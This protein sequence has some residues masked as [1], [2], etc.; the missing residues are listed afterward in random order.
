MDDLLS[1]VKTTKTQSKH[2]ESK[3]ILTVEANK[4]STIPLVEELRSPEQ[5]IIILQSRPSLKALVNVLRWLHGSTSNRA[6]FNIHCPSPKAAQIIHL[7]VN[8]VLPSY[9]SSLRREAKDLLVLTLSNLAGISAIVTRMRFLSDCNNDHGEQGLIKEDEKARFL[10]DLL[11][12][13]DA[14]LKR[15]SFILFLWTNLAAIY[16]DSM[17]RWISWKEVVALL[18]SGRLLSTASQADDVVA[19][20]ASTTRQRSW[21][22]DGSRYSSWIGRNLGY[23]LVSSEKTDG[24]RRKAWVHMLQRALT[25]G[26]PGEKLSRCKVYICHTPAYGIVGQ[27]IEA[28]YSGTIKSS[29]DLVS[30][31]RESTMALQGSTRRVVLYSLLRMY[32]NIYFSSPAAKYKGENSDRRICCVAALIHHFLGD[33]DNLTGILYSWLTGAGIVQDL[34]LRRAVIAALAVKPGKTVAE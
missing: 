20:T 8:D 29:S 16:P 17:H 27:V 30:T 19:K 21:L 9:W 6:D 15:D 28:A 18:A 25:M 24:D 7:L 1:P 3:K 34:R 13:L 26:H 4:A 11:S 22:A 12:V 2:L 10:E 5:A 14:T 32:S 31:Y 33:N 23:L